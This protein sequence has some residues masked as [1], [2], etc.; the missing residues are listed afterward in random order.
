MDDLDELLLNKGVAAMLPQKEEKKDTRRFEFAR[1]ITF[2][3]YEFDIK[4]CLSVD[5][6]R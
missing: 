4:F 3:K 2:L 6:R 1:L 5:K